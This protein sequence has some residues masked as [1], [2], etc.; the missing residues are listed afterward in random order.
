MGILKLQMNIALENKWDKGMSE[1]SIINLNDVDCILHGKKTAEGFIPY[2]TEVANN[3]AD[4]EHELGKQIMKKQQTIFSNTLKFHQWENT[5]ILSGEIEAGIKAKLAQ[6]ENNILVYGGETFAS[7]LLALNLVDEVYLFINP[8]SIGN[9]H[10][11]F[12]PISMLSD[13]TLTQTRV[14]ESGTILLKYSK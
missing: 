1:F 3:Q 12:N 9:G 5:N 13:F 14:F 6:T 2:W 7:S 10:K 4:P 8:V 11:T